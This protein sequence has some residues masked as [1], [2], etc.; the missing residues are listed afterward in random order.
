[1]SITLLGIHLVFASKMNPTYSY[2]SAVVS[3]VAVVISSVRWL[4]VAQREHYIPG[5]TSRFALRWYSDRYRVVNPI[6]AVLAAIAGLVVV[7]RPDDLLP[8]GIGFLAVLAATLVAPRGLSYR[9][10]T[11]PLNY[12]RRLTTLA[13]LT[14]LINVV[15]VGLGAWFGLG[16]AF[17]VVA[18]ILLPACVD[19]ALLL[20]LPI[21]R[22]N[23]SKFVD[24]A[25]KKLEKLSPRVVAITGSY[26]KTSTKVY[27]AH[28]V[29]ST[30]TTF[31]SP[32]SFNNRAGLARAINEG[33]SPGTEV[34]V[35]EMGTFKKGEIADLCRWIPPD[36]SVITSIGPVHLERFGSEDNIVEA[37]SEIAKNASVVVLNAD[38]HYLAN[39]ART[40]SAEGKRLVMVSGK[41]INADVAVKDDDEG[42]LV[43]YAGQRRMCSMPFLDIS[44]TNIAAAVAV[45]LELGVPESNIAERLATLPVAKN[46]L[47][48]STN[49]SGI[50]VLDDTYN[51][52]PA[53][54]RLALG[55]LER[56][57]SP[58][59][60]A[61]IVTPGMI[62]LGKKQFEENSFLG[63]AA[64]RIATDVVIVGYT[65]RRALLEG[66][67]NA[68]T[69]GFKPNVLLV[70]SRGEAVR[71]VRENL[72]FGDAVLYENDLPDHFL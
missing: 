21:E 45:S 46:R 9:G 8:A 50:T 23:L 43:I 31:A 3:F 55:A 20:T 40:L 7:A 63:R 64:A 24:R 36:I 58:L 66:V 33:L 1:M 69:E 65:N 30:F 42:N 29:S 60:R 51:S 35:A 52:N 59:C 27:I 38:N 17:G 11:S 67:S 14:W 44:Q 12:T 15:F 2:L 6:L 56:R 49:E 41:D 37:K 34:L 16:M 32:A 39:L 19:L 61:V 53:G 54:A 68:E 18:M 5:Y 22:R 10:S 47:N 4:R 62:E 28:L 70:G 72:T 71:W 57:K 48:L 25:A 26:G 13:I